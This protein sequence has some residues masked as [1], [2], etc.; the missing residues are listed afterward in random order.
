MS[1]LVYIVVVAA[2]FLVVFGVGF[3]W[4]SGSPES[5]VNE[6]DGVAI[7]GYDPVAYFIKGEAV[8]GSEEFTVEYEDAVWQ[9][10][11]PE[12][13]DLF[14]ADPEKYAPAYGGY[15]AWAVSNGDF[16]DID[17]EQWVIHEGTLYLNFDARTNRRF[18]EDL[19]GNIQKAESNWPEM[20][21]RIEEG[22]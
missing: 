4:A 11:S 5:V 17:P 8:E 22:S 1:K 19:P 3:L 12:H 2:T 18:N 10:S 14:L 15:C 13:R 9:F 20:K 7:K 6:R 21:S 16:A